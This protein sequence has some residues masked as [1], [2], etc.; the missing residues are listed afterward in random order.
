MSR[1]LV[2][3]G[4][5][6]GLAVL[7]GFVALAAG[8]PALAQRERAGRP[9]HLSWQASLAPA[10]EPGEALVVSGTV[11]AAD[12]KTPASG[13]V[14]YAYQ[15]DARGLYTNDGRPGIPRLHGWMRTDARGRYEFRTIRPASYPGQTVAAHIHMSVE[16]DGRE[17]TIDDIHFEG[18]PL[19]T[20]SMRQR[21]VTE[22]PFSTLCRATADAGGVLRCTRNIRL[23]P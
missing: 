10:G 6:A 3:G 4:R 17:Q 8:P 14:V 1:V 23:G 15:T 18:D 12:G 7:T 22:G 11:F 16:E 2:G 9:A 13:V 20:A 5:A 19:L 21:T